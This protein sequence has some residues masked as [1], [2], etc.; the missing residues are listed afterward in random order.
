MFVKSNNYQEVKHPSLKKLE[1]IIK[2][3][4]QD[5]SV[6]YLALTH[7]S[8]TSDSNERLEFLGD[9][10]LNLII[11]DYL[12]IKYPM[13]KE[14]R[15]SRIRAQIISKPSLQNV[16][17]K[18]EIANYI[19][20]GPAEKKVF[21]S[22]NQN[23]SIISDAIEAIIGAIYIDGGIEAARNSILYLFKEELDEI[24]LDKLYKDSKTIL[25]E[26]VQ[27]VYHS[28]PVYRLKSQKITGRQKQEFL[29]Y[30]K[31]PYHGE[32]FIGKG[33]SRKEAEKNAA[34]IALKSLPKNLISVE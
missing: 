18:I 1:G 11:S 33:T 20:M 32:M 29:I 7:K 14:G 34:S 26:L 4:F 15:L 2:Y 24:D 16:A 27:S 3:D 6:A 28:V 25:Q 13:A 21:G 17:N 5:T 9:A 31:V 22:N 30:C 8:L 10:I 23:T 19:R 12:Y